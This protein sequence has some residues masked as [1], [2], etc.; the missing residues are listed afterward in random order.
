MGPTPRRQ[1]SARGRPDAFGVQ[2]GDG[3]AAG[4]AVD[5]ARCHDRVRD[6]AAD[7]DRR[8][9]DRLVHLRLRLHDAGPGID[10]QDGPGVRGPRD[11]RRGG[12]GGPGRR[13]A[14]LHDPGAGLQ[15][16]GG[17]GRSARRHGGAGV[18]DRQAPGSAAARSRRRGDHHRG[19]E[20]RGLGVDHHR[21]GASGR[22]PHQTQGLQ[23]RIG[24][25]HRG[26]R[27]DLRRRRPPRAP[28]AAPGGGGIPRSC[29]TTSPASR[30]NWPTTT[31]TRTC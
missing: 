14:A 22:T 12:P 6:L 7:G 29:P 21:S 16:A 24:V 18:P 10:L 20:L 28:A 26:H 8:G 19:A 27:H 1:R 17:G 5:A 23:L 15:R 2:P 3:L 11:L 9:A 31:A 30:P 4:G 25:R 13:T